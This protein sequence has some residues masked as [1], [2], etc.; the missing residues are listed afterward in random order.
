M[1][2]CFSR[3][4]AFPVALRPSDEGEVYWIPKER[5]PECKLASDMD[6]MLEIFESDDLTE[7]ITTTMRTVAGDIKCYRRRTME[8]GVIL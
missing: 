7:F 4:I 8:N 6:E 3:P 2:F 1:W 5:L